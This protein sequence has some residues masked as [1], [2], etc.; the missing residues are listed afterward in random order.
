MIDVSN[1]PHATA[2]D[3][4]WLARD[5][6]WAGR[7]GRLERVDLTTLAPMRAV[8]GPPGLAIEALAVAPGTRIAVATERAAWLV[9]E[10]P[11]AT[12]F[13]PGHTSEVSAIAIAART[14][15]SAG[16]DGRL[17]PWL[18]AGGELAYHPEAPPERDY[19]FQY[20]WGLPGVFAGD[21]AR[22]RHLYFGACHRDGAR[23]VSRFWQAARSRGQGSA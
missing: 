6:S 8:E 18:A 11:G 20:G 1:E 16:L 4:T 2:I 22:R 9:D 14:V 5:A 10:H 15:V 3:Q 23:E 19:L 17:V 7:P 13:L 21:I 12:G